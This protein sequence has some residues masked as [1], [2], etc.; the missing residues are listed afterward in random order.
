MAEVRSAAARFGPVAER[1]FAAAEAAHKPA[2]TAWWVDE[3]DKPRPRG[4][5]ADGA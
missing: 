1:E 5:R 4:E 2:L 3:L